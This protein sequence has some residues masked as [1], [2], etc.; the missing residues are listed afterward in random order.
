LPFDKLAAGLTDTLAL[1]RR[2]RFFKQAFVERTSVN[3]SFSE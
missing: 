2:A 3:H 1:T